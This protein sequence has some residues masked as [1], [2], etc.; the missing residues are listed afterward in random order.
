MWA[1]LLVFVV[2]ALVTRSL[3]VLLAGVV[4]SIAASVAMRIIGR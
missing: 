3:A 2:I 1:V 4:A